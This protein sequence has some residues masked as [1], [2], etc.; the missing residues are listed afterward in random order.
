M[1]GVKGKSGRKKKT[2]ELANTAQILSGAA[3]HAARY[4]RDIAT[5]KVT[6]P[7]WSKIDVAKYILDHELGKPRIKA[8]LTGASGVPLDWRGILILAGIAEQAENEGE[9]PKI[10]GGV[11][12]ITMEA[13]EPPGEGE[14]EPISQS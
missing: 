7:S 14:E 3:P 13:S 4:L 9:V 12:L 5:G 6:K 2:V 1:T 8:E 11:K 10:P